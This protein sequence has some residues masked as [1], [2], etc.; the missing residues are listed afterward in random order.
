MYVWWLAIDFFCES[1]ISVCCAHVC[2][3]KKKVENAA[4]HNGLCSDDTDMSGSLRGAKVL[5]RL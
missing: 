4:L 2:F 3:L 1:V 5:A